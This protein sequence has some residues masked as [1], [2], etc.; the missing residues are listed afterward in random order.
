MDMFNFLPAWAM[1]MVIFL[2]RIID[3]S[4]GTMRTLSIVEGQIRVSVILG[5]FEVLF[6]VFAVSQ[7]IVRLNESLVLP[8]FYA[9]GFAAGNAVGLMLE[10]LISERQVVVRMIS[11][12]GNEIT[13]ALRAGEQNAAMFS[14]QDSN[15]PVDLIY[16]Q[17]P[18]S[19]VMGMLK[20]AR[21]IDPN[22]IFVVERRNTL[23][24]CRTAVTHPSGWRAFWKKK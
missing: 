7:V 23:E 6:W 2:A 19:K 12:R 10:K 15:G 16:T 13:Q 5:F 14:G 24:Y 11:I 9:G 22:L 4:L 8:L 21:I 18:R 17:C 20:R 3:V 1:A